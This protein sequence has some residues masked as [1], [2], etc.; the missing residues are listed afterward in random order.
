MKREELRTR[1]MPRTGIQLSDLVIDRLSESR[2]L[3]ASDGMVSLHGHEVSLSPEEEAAALEMEKI[4]L[5]AGFAPPLPGEITLQPGGRVDR[6]QLLSLLIDRGILVR[7]AP[8]ILMHRDKVDQAWIIVRQL[9]EQEGRISLAEFRDQLETSRKFAM[10][11]LEYFDKLKRTRLT[12][13]VRIFF[14]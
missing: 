13:E 11:L 12:G 7:L 9:I 14:S 3:V 6:T 5:E 2:I 10:A 8:Q 1:L 4:F